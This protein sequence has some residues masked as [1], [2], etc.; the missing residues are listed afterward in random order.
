MTQDEDENLLVVL[1]QNGDTAAFE[2]LLIRIHRPL[3]SYATKMVGESMVEDILQEI[4]L[5]IYRQIRF[6][7]EPRAFRASVYRTATRVPIPLGTALILARLP[8]RL[9]AHRFLSQA[10]TGAYSP[11]ERQSPPWRGVSSLVPVSLRIAL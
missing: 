6:L 11:P 4:P 8:H 10:A 3:R 2:K 7:K 5:Q 9:F 1:V